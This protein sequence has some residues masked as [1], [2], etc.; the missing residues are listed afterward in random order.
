MGQTQ[1]EEEHLTEAQYF[2]SQCSKFFGFELNDDSISFDDFVER[3]SSRIFVYHFHVYC[4]VLPEEMK[5]PHKEPDP[6]VPLTSFQNVKRIKKQILEMRES[7]QIDVDVGPIYLKNGNLHPKPSFEIQVQEKS[8]SKV[9]EF[10]MMNVGTKNTV[11]IHPNA[12][13]DVKNHGERVCCIGEPLKFAVQALEDQQKM[14]EGFINKHRHSEAPLL[15]RKIAL[16]KGLQNYLFPKRYGV[17]DGFR[18][19]QL[20]KDD[21]TQG[22]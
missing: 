5:D 10:M 2:G 12:I 17:V 19:Q 4:D 13:N 11:L 3:I 14:V 15:E 6:G 1:S 16:Y 18:N 7:G 22:N 8:L 9:I 20:V 21:N